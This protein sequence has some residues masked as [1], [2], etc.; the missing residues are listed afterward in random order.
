MS[1]KRLEQR[2]EALE[3]V[4]DDSDGGGTPIR[5]VSVEGY[6]GDPDFE[7]RVSEAEAEAGRTGARLLVVSKRR[8][9]GGDL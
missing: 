9:P 1:T 2:I 8:W 4:A 5:W 3:R 6:V 7:A